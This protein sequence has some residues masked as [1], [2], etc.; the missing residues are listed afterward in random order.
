MTPAEAEAQID[1]I[2]NR[3]DNAYFRTTPSTSGSRL[4]ELGKFIAKD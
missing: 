2:M 3:A 1:E 4:V